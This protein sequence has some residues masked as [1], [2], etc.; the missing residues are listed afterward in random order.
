MNILRDMVAAIQILIAGG[1]LFRVV[2]ILIQ[3]MSNPDDKEAGKKRIKN[4]IT[5]LVIAQSI[6]VIV[7]LI[8]NYY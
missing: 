5:F 2:Y 7:N 1:V 3:I 4:A 8:R 6:L